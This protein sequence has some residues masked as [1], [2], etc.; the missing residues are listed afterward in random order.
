MGQTKGSNFVTRTLSG[1]V[2][3]VVVVGAVLWS[4]WTFALL[5]MAICGGALW[6][7]YGM[8]E[9]KGLRPHKW[10]A[11]VLGI[12]AVGAWTAYYNWAL[13]LYVTIAIP[14]VLLCPFAMIAIELYRKHDNPM[15]NIGITFLGLIYIAVPLCLFGFLYIAVGKESEDMGVWAILWYI[16]IIWMNDI[17]AYLFGVAFGRHRLFE[18]ISPKKSWEGFFGGLLVGIGTGVAA[19]LIMGW[20]VW[21]WAGLGAVAVVSGVF[22]DLVESMF[23][24]SAGVKD[25]GNLIPG[26]GGMLDRFDALIFSIPFVFVYFLIFASL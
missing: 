7:F 18:R 25:S 2:L 21:F 23:K 19:A 16:F 22:G 4:P 8:A 26:H 15:S 6:E 24:R 5:L 10:M 1:I 13:M 9:K 12:I 20:D 11:I 3:L 17:G 14:I